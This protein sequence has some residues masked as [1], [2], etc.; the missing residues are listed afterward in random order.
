MTVY[1]LCLDDNTPSGGRRVLYRHVDI[2][3]EAGIEAAIAHVEKDFRLTWFA[4][5]TRVLSAEE[6]V[7]FL[8]E[9]DIF[10]IP[11]TRG[12][13][14][15]RTVPDFPF[16]I[17]NQNAYY[18][19]N[20]YDFSE[21][22][23]PYHAENLRGVMVVSEDSKRYLSYAFPHLTP[24]RVKVS[25]DPAFRYHAEKENVIACMPRKHADELVAALNICKWRGVL[26]GWTVQVVDKM[27]LDEVA[28]HLGRAAVFL[29]TG[30]P[31]GSPMPPLEALASG[32]VVAGYLGKGGEEYGQLGGIIRA[33][34]SDVQSLAKALG[35]AVANWRSFDREAAS[36]A[37]R[38]VYSREEEART[39]L[40]FWRGVL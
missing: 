36:R 31:E 7:P 20:G 26:N 12:P 40:E 27:T 2:L 11:E 32:C 25:M 9:D 37:A 28:Y 6:I 14:L 30:Y 1:Y 8:K 35:A 17:F 3:N 13:D 4:N 5:E 39:V 21:Q 23:T 24:E 16:V 15:H 29:S 18:T 33:K 34:D 19:W 10:V 22:T 38:E